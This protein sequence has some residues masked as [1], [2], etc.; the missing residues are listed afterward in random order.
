MFFPWDGSGEPSHGESISCRS[1]KVVV[2]KPRNCLGIIDD[3][4]FRYVTD[5]GLRGPNKGKGGRFLL[6]PPGYKGDVPKIAGRD[7]A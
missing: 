1:P 6:L 3:F 2:E 7:G 5:V 4:W